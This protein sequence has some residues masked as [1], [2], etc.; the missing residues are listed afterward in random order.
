MP[1]VRYLTAFL[2]SLSAVN[3][4]AAN[5]NTSA[6]EDSQWLYIDQGDGLV[7]N[8]PAP[9][10]QELLGQARQL[11]SSLLNEREKIAQTVKDSEFKAKDG[12][13]TVLVP[14][15]LLY[16][17]HKKLKHSR[18]KKKLAQVTSQLDD[19]TKGLAMLQLATG[20]PTVA[21]LDQ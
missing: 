18:A 17:S 13:I 11:N 10:T 16:A 21:M 2:L 6:A 19:L 1:I 9:D 7:I 20:E 12:L 3:V 15:G 4:Y 5:P 14:G 8:I